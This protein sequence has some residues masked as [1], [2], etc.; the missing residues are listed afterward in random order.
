MAEAP[1]EPDPEQGKG[2]R[3]RSGV[4]DVAAASL[5]G[6]AGQ[7]SGISVLTTFL[8]ATLHSGPAAL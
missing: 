5:F 4:G 6:G 1:T 8:T 7:E 3:L 2:R